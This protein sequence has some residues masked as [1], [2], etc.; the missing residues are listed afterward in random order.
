MPRIAAPIRPAGGSTVRFTEASVVVVTSRC[1]LW[2]GRDRPSRLSTSSV[3]IS[4]PVHPVKAVGQSTPSVPRSTPG[5]KS[6][7]LPDCLVVRPCPS[8][9]RHAPGGG[10]AGRL[11]GRRKRR[12]LGQ[13][14]PHRPL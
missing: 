4:G 12:Q 5:S 14:T 7:P 1:L 2:L 8:A 3:I 10:T 6:S 13:A 9:L 11:A